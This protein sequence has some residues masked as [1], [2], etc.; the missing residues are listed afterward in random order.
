MLSSPGEINHGGVNSGG[1]GIWKVIRSPVTGW[2]MA[3][4]MAASRRRGSLAPWG[5]RAT[6]LRGR[7]RDITDFP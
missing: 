2:V 6:D 3:S 4:R 1:M 5:G 7:R